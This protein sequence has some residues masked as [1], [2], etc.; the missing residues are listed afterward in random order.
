MHWTYLLLKITGDH[1]AMKNV[2][3]FFVPFLS[4]RSLVSSFICH[5]LEITKEE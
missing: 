3:F 5:L 2:S 1:S 4:S